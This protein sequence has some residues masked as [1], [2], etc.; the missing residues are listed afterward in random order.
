MCKRMSRL[1]T[2]V[3][4]GVV[5]VLTGCGEA[6]EEFSSFHPNLSY[7]NGT[8]L[9]ATIASAMDPV[10]TGV[11]CHVSTRFSAGA[12]YFVFANNQGLSSEVIFNAIDSRQQSQNRIGMNNGIIVGFSIFGDGFFAFDAQCPDCFDYNTLPVRN[13][14]LTFTDTGNVSC[15]HCG[16]TFELNKWPNGLTRYRATTTGPQGLLRVF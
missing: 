5:A 15:K 9:D 1:L 16:R 6:T 3:L 7:D 14:P 12:Y 13:Y 4:W 2:A 10:S 11:W 8:H